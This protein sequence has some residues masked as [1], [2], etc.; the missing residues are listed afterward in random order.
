MILSS[1][2]G[3]ALSSNVRESYVVA[4]AKQRSENSTKLLT[5]DWNGKA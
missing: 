2:K 4:E 3:F 5:L 1:P